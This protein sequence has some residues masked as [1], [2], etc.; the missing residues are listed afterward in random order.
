MKSKQLIFSLMVFFFVLIGFSQQTKLSDNEAVELRTDIVKKSES[1]SSIKSEFVQLKHL[2]FLSNDIKSSG[3]LYYKSPNFI[4]WEYQDPFVYSATFKGDML[5]IN[6]A[7]KKSDLDLSS[8][9]AF[10]SLNNLVVKSVKG[11]LFDDTEFEISYFK[12]NKNY[13]VHFIPKDKK[14]KKFISEFVIGFDKI[15]FEVLSVKMLESSEDYTL[16]IFNNQQFNQP[17]ADAV[18]DN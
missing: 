2:S 9:K 11:D 16:L 1:T 5:F 13:S 3:M 14:L 6:D 18:F 17:I 12:N 4:K 10:K 15:T 8:N 7:G